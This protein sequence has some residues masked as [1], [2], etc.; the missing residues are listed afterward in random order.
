MA[1]TPQ[2]SLQP[3]ENRP[4]SGSPERGPVS[5]LLA[6]TSLVYDAYTPFSPRGPADKKSAARGSP[7]W[8]RFRF[9]CYPTATEQPTAR[10]PRPMWQATLKGRGAMST[11]LVPKALRSSFFQSLASSGL[12]E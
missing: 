9:F 5:L 1:D 10:A 11:R 7:P 2:T 6:V 8:P 3:Q 12:P 4:S